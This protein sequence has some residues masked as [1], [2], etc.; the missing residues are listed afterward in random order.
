MI[1]ETTYKRAKSQRGAF[2]INCLVRNSHLLPLPENLKIQMLQV[3]FLLS[4]MDYSHLSDFF[5]IFV[6]LQLQ[7]C[8]GAFLENSTLDN[9]SMKFH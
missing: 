5:F 7:V 8:T 3:R 9:I 1:S 6:A 2:K 4:L